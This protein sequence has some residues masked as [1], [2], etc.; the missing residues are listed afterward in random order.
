M[1]T[2]PSSSADAFPTDP[3]GLP[4]SRGSEVL[5]VPDGGEIELRIAPVAKSLGEDVVRMLAYN[6]SIPGPTLKVQEGSEVV[7]N[8]TT[9]A[10]WRRRFTGTGCGWRTATTEHMRR[11]HPCRW[12][13]R[14]RTGSR[15]L[16]P[17]ST[18]TTRTSARTTARSW[19]CTGTSS[20]FRPIRT[21]GRRSIGR[22]C[23][24]SMTSCSRTG[25]SRR[26]AGQ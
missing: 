5:E 21:T 19:G 22:S 23:S 7:V 11:R 2:S 9:R 26:S 6:G 20:S 25:K 10:T 14:S 13:G 17:A 24:R 18:G 1:T 3:S 4:E 12:V 15:F 8:V 16:T